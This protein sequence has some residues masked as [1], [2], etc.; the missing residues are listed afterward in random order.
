LALKPPR[1]QIRR[2][3]LADGPGPKAADLILTKPAIAFRH[4]TKSDIATFPTEWVLTLIPQLD[5]S[6]HAQRVVGLDRI[7]AVADGASVVFDRLVRSECVA[8]DLDALGV[9]TVDQVLG[10]DRPLGV[11]RIG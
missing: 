11:N 2:S 1:F 3:E 5:R 8:E 4:P 6:E 10:Q 7:D 9:T